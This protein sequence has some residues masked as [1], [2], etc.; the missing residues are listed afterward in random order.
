MSHCV[1]CYKHQADVEFKHKL[2]L[3][4]ETRVDGA[5]HTRPP[6]TVSQTV[7]QLVT[8]RINCPSLTAESRVLDS[9]TVSGCK[10]KTNVS[11]NKS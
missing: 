4:P 8:C 7:K 1:E 10:Q 3:W 5:V 11:S 6:L 2:P 9:V